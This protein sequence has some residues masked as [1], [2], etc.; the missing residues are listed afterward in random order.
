VS[1]T[2]GIITAMDDEPLD[3]ETSDI[4]RKAE[5]VYL[6]ML[7]AFDGGGDAQQITLAGARF[8]DIGAVTARRDDEQDATVVNPTPLIA[9]SLNLLT[10]L[11]NTIKE[12]RPELTTLR[13]LTA[14]RTTIDVEA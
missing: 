14:V 3:D 5:H 10:L 1:A 8:Q 9:A 2:Q 11:I 4:I 6:D 13:I 7:S 12:Q